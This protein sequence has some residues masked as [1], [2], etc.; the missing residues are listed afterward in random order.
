MI[1][2][3]CFLNQNVRQDSLREDITNCRK[4]VHM[5]DNIILGGN[6]ADGSVS[7]HGKDGQPLVEL[8]GRDN[9]AVVGAGNKGRPGRLSMYDGAGGNTVN[10]TTADASLVLGGSGTDGRVSVHGKD[11]QPL[12]E[13]LG[14]DNEA[15]IGLGQAGRP[16]RISVYDAQQKEV[17][18]LDGAGGDIWIANADC[19]EEFDVVGEGVEPGSVVVL[20][21]DGVAPCETAYDTRV[22]GIVSGAGMFRPGLV[23]DRRTTGL[24]RAP[25]ALLGKVCCLVDATEQPVR[26]GDLLT[27]ST[28]RGHAMRARNFRRARGAIL[29]KALRSL[30]NGQGLVPVLVTLQ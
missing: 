30:S 22:V 25:I 16:G 11:G 12:V 5:S 27:S 17:V 4:N 24:K 9:E 2:G 28:R 23:L 3:I 1:D 6:G 7:V 18:R 20:T 14:R 13:L 15:V 21:D 19:A 29:G 10:L 26:I 8:L